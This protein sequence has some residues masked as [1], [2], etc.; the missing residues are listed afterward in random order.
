VDFLD[1]SIQPGQAGP[2]YR[3]I[4]DAIRSAIDQGRLS[5]GAR[6]PAIRRL[7][8]DLAV[9]R[10]TVAVAYEALA[11]EGLVESVVGRGTFVSRPAAA[12]PEEQAE[13]QLTA[14]VERLL[15]IGDARTRF[16]AAPEAIPLHSLVPD[17][18][19]YPLD[20]FRRA[21]NR[22]LA[23]GGAELF[24][25]GSA[26][27]HAGL[28]AV[29]ADR[30]AGEGIQV[31][32]EDIVLCHGASQ[33]ISLALRLFA[34]SGDRVAVESPTYQNVLA[35]LAG[36]G[37]RPVSVE[38][39]P[40]GP[41]LDALERV[42][43]QPDVK[44]FYTIP[45]FHNPMGITTSPAHRRAVLDI[46][47]RC[48]KPIVEDAFEMDLRSQGRPVPTLAAMDPYGLVVHLYSFSKSLFPGLRV[49]SITPPVSGRR[50]VDAL[51]ALKQS[52][53]LSDS[54]PLQAALA[55]FIEDGA[56]DRHLG[57]IRRA[58]RSR[59]QAMQDALERHLPPGTR[60]TRPDGGYQVWLELPVALD[61]R[62]LVA[63][64][65]RQGVLFSP[66][67]QFLHDGAAS[68]CLRLTL[69]RAGPEEI[70][71]GI[72]ALGRAVAGRLTDQGGTMPMADIHL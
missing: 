71:C 35:S 14:D 49:G 32:A 50:A 10:D 27:G 59:H 60:W 29:L 55:E 44:A 20:D 66:G 38:M 58:L 42:L 52:T 56:Y 34:S 40:E 18:A 21:L 12:L 31:E 5:V 3:Q 39:S 1:L 70:E 36:L 43:S 33:G 37:M 45:T 28:R 6:L 72:E 2:V 57:R 11:N 63:D 41:D 61:T 25:Y 7:A 67:A 9:N 19:L 8:T 48:G 69:A 23:K 22:A 17:P 15:A 51:V 24:L 65:A 13:L 53:D 68:R 46:A 54:M 30:F 16:G 62:D 4:A 26:Q 64:A 47:R